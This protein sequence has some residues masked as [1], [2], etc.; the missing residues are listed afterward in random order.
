MRLSF[1][2]LDDFMRD[3]ATMQVARKHLYMGPL[4]VYVRLTTRRMGSVVGRTLD[5]ADISVDSNH[6]RQGIFRQFL[7]HAERIAGRQGVS[8]YVESIVNPELAN[9]LQRRGYEFPE[10]SVDRA[11]MSADRLKQKHTPTDETTLGL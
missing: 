8:L 4:M 6:Q 2:A 7:D 10:A 5:L 11:W 9:A 1:K 3:N